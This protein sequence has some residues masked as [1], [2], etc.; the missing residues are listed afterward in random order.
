MQIATVGGADLIFVQNLASTGI[1]EVAIDLAATV[2]GKTADT[3]SD[4]V[5]F[6]GTTGGDTIVLS[7]LGNKVTINGLATA[8]SVDHVGQDGYHQPSSAANG[9][10]LDFCRDDRRRQG[11]S[12]DSSA[13]TA[14]TAIVGSNGNNSV[15]GGTGND[16]IILGAGN[17]DFICVAGDGTDEVNGGAGN[18]TFK[19]EWAPV[20]GISSSL[21]TAG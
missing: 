14:T 21:E 18:D 17:D 5:A 20:S 7:M 9:P 13:G 15:I 16:T 10:D 6:S 12:A 2:G 19:Y 8:A 3:K 4:A 1:G 11:R